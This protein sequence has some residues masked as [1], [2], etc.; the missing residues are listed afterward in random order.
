MKNLLALNMKP[1]C[2][3]Q[4]PNSFLI[5]LPTSHQPA[6]DSNV[7]F[8][9]PGAP[10][11]HNTHPIRM[12]LANVHYRPQRVRIAGWWPTPDTPCA[13]AAMPRPFPTSEPSPVA[14]RGE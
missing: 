5:S 14:L 13:M 11:P 6:H 12:R 4:Y 10:T 7:A 9:N 1:I 3:I 2:L 8:T